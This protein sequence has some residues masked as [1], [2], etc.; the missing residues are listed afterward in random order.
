[1]LANGADINSKNEDGELEHGAFKL[2]VCP[3]LAAGEG[4]VLSPARRSPCGPLLL[5]PGSS[6]QCSPGRIH[7][8][9]AGYTSLSSATSTTGPG[10][11]G[12]GISG[13]MWLRT[14]FANLA[15]IIC[16]S[17]LPSLPVSHEHALGPPT[18]PH[19]FFLFPGS[20]ALHLATISCQPQCVKVLLQ[21]RVPIPAKGRSG[22]RG[23]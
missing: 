6:G 14:S 15:L 20:T 9:A 12:T 10:T 3:F 23:S 17:L 7:F 1:M 8:R 4:P 16:V 11:G 22:P 19:S 5:S 2:F 18:L 13:R 21:V